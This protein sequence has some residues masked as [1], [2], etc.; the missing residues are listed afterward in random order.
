MMAKRE[1]I[2]TYSETTRLLKIMRRLKILHGDKFE[3][4]QG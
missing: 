2:I 4:T 3:E 1:H